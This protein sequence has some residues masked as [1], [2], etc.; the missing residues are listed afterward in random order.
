M[1]KGRSPGM[2]DGEHKSKPMHLNLFYPQYIN[3][4]NDYSV[5][6]ASV[7]SSSLIN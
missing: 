1:R 2:W 4:Y 7:V 3:L 5:D 6:K